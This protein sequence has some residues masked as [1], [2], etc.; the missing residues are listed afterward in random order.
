MNF[1]VKISQTEIEFFIK[2][3][4]TTQDEPSFFAIFKRIAMMTEPQLVMNLEGCTFMDS[5]AMG[6]LVTACEEAAKRNVVRVLRGVHPEM[7]TLLL[8]VGFENFYYFQ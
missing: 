8:S 5:A 1:S 4:F 7:K 3:S 6:M 2:G